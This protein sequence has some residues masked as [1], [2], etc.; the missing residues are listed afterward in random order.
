V[1]IRLIVEILDHAPPD[2]SLAER[3]VL[4]V[5]AEE[6]NDATRRGWPPLEVIADR[7]GLDVRGAESALRRLRQRGYDI[8][9]ALKVGKDG[10]PVYAWRGRSVTYSMPRF[11]RRDGPGAERRA[12]GVAPSTEKGPLSD[13]PSTE[14][15]PL[16]GAERP[17][18]QRERPADG[19]GPSP[20]SPHI[21][22]PARA[23]EQSPAAVAGNGGRE[24]HKTEPNARA[25]LARIRAERK[26]PLTETELLDLAYEIG[27]DP[28]YDGFQAIDAATIASFNGA[29][30][31]RKVLR[32]RLG[33]AS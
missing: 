5:I 25:A 8:R 18:V 19:V 11:P 16:A 3:L 7:A 10:R 24:P 21:P 27:P 6:A 23:R 2:L 26:L 28:Y 29:R 15:G 1:S 33:L 22:P 4:I 17:A 9:V 13:G 31:I 32:S 14:K 30:D 12:A 20:Q